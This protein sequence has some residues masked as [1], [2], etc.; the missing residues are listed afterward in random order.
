MII[1]WIP[2]SLASVRVYSLM[3]D[4]FG[5]CL[6]DKEQEGGDS[7]PLKSTELNAVA[8][9]ERHGC[10]KT[11]SCRN[12]QPADHPNDHAVGPLLGFA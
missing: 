1:R 4:D 7:V 8:C 6:V 2:L 3:K 5:R 10:W 12:I 9:E 11:A